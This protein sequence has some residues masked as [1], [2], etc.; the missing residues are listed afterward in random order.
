MARNNVWMAFLF[1]VWC[2]AFGIT[3]LCF[4]LLLYFSIHQHAG[5]ILKLFGSVTELRLR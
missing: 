4:N 5:K 1:C 3:G 2:D